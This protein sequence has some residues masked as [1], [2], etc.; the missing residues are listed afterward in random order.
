MDLSVSTRD[1]D[2]RV[3]ARLLADDLTDAGDTYWAA[4]DEL[5][6]SARYAINKNVEI[7]FLTGLGRTN[8]SLQQVLVT[9]WPTCLGNCIEMKN[10]K[11]CSSI[12]QMVKVHTFM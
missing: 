3:H 6:F 11:L 8:R 7:Y 9:F 2:G 10:M 1:E 5:D 12:L 4:D